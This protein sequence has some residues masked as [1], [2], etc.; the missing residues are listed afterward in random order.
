[1]KTRLL[2]MLILS[3][4]TTALFFGIV[5]PEVSTTPKRVQDYLAK[6]PATMPP[7]KLPAFVVSESPLPETS[8]KTSE[9]YSDASDAPTRDCTTIKSGGG[10]S[11]V[12]APDRSSVANE[13]TG[14]TK[15]AKIE[16]GK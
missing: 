9:S 3:V 16:V 1:M 8:S 13:I 6:D 15:Q 4:G 11:R 12:N 2:W 7:V 14:G 5:R 10:T